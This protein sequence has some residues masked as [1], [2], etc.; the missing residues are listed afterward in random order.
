[1]KLFFNIKFN[2]AVLL[3]GLIILA[4]FL[5][6]QPQ[7]EG[8]SE[9]SGYNTP[10]QLAAQKSAR[11]KADMI[12]DKVSSGVKTVGD[13]VDSG[14]NKIASFF[15]T[16]VKVNLPKWRDV[17]GNGISVPDT[18]TTGLKP[19]T[20]LILVDGCS[21]KSIMHSDYTNDFCSV[22]QGDYE[23]IDT[24]C[25]ALS[26]DNCGLPSCCVLLNG[27]KCVA[28]DAKGP[29]Y[30]T[31]QGNQID[32]YYY[33]YRNKCYG[34][35]CN[36]SSSKYQ[37]ICGKYAD[38]STNV[39]Q[40]CMVQ[41]FNK[42]G[43]TSP[44]P[45]FVIND[46]YVYNNSKSSKKYIQNDLIATAKT[47]LSE[48]SKGNQDSRIK[49]SGDPSNPCDQFLSTDAGVS[50]ACMVKMYNDAG[51]PNKVAPMIT[52]DMVYNYRNTN[53]DNVK[54]IIKTATELLKN[55]ADS[56]QTPSSIPLCYGTGVTVSPNARTT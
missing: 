12:G 52:D 47:L 1:M 16:S 29:T 54:K 46:D 5:S 17:Y 55:G 43:C 31:D 34:A 14:L 45:I 37:Q 44:K 23:T 32:Y 3:L 19:D 39:S 53:K 48:I 41:M 38:N 28:G 10:A 36:D 25:K 50:K 33:L 24:K 2:I 6:D 4:L 40:D 18:V 49:C 21:K 42:A 27:T 8:F 30:L 15:D 13:S 9:Y 22:Y 51:C 56:G 26:I 11:D 7:K 20:S 35:G